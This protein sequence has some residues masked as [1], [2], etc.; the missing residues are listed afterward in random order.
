MQA[1]YVHP[2]SSHLSPTDLGSRPKDADLAAVHGDRRWGSRAAALHASARI[3]APAL[4]PSSQQVWA[5]SRSGGII[6]ARASSA[7]LQEGALIMRQRTFGA[8]TNREGAVL[9]PA[10]ADFSSIPN[11]TGDAGYWTVVLIHAGMASDV[12]VKQAVKQ[13]RP[14]L[15]PLVCCPPPHH[16][17]RQ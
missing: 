7:D 3:P 11:I 5:R 8:T 2:E 10:A 17:R 1:A 6:S 9:S 16:C 14:P 4:H 13:P 12:P 15:P